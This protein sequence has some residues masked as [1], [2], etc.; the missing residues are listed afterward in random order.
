MGK[1]ETQKGG[2]EAESTPKQKGMAKT[3]FHRGRKNGLR[4]EWGGKRRNNKHGG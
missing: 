1:N 2:G 4:A 3:F